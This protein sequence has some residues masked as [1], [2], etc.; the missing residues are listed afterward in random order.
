MTEVTK[1]QLDRIGVPRWQWDG[2]TEDAQ[3]EKLAAL[4]A[5]D[6]QNAEK[7]PRKVELDRLRSLTRLAFPGDDAEFATW[8]EAHGKPDAQASMMRH[9]LATVDASNRVGF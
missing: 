1:L 6:R 4:A 8:W 2:M 5:E 9:A 7:D 3:R